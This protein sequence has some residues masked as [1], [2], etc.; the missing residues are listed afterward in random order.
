V[1]KKRRDE[2]GKKRLKREMKILLKK[3]MGNDTISMGKER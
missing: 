3:R 1:R 2:G